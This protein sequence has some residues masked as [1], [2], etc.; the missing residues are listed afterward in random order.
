MK[1]SYTICEVLKY[2]LKIDCDKLKRCIT[3][4]KQLLKDKCTLKIL[5][6]VL[7]H[8]TKMNIAVTQVTHFFFF[9]SAYKSY[10]YTIQQ[11]VK[12]VIALCLK[13]IVHILVLKYFV[14]KKC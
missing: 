7:D 8:C 14:A 5:S 12:C 4:P 3:N 6:S 1:V 11:S 2:H 9:P 13:S 10:I